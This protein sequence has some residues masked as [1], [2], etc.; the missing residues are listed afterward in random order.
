MACQNYYDNIPRDIRLE[1]KFQGLG[2]CTVLYCLAAVFKE[3]KQIYL[4]Y[5]YN[6][7]NR[8]KL[9]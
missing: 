6:I 4:F 7:N 3:P 2:S 1:V 9:L 5:E 8:H